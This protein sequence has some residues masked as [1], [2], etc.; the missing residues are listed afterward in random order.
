MTSQATQLAI[1]LQPGAA[2]DRIDSWGT[3][4]D[5][6]PVLRIRV[7]ARP[8]EGE[9]NAALTLFMVKALDLPKSAVRL[10]RGDR[11][12]LKRL[13]VEG[14]DAAELS[15]RIDGILSER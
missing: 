5:G 13:E 12:R 11:S 6:R 14:L 2:V 8:V 1:K 15:A 3:D 7:R 9:A 10:A 4:A